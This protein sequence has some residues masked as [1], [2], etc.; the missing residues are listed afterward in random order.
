[1]VSLFNVSCVVVYLPPGN[2]VCEGYVF[3][4]VCHSVHM[5]GGLPQCMLCWDTI[6]PGPGTTLGADHPPGADPPT[7]HPPWTR[8]P[9]GPCTPLDQAPPPRSRPPQ[10]PPWDQAPPTQC[11]LGDTVNKQVVCIP[12]ECNLVTILLT[13]GNKIAFH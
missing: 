10:A 4:R 1:M 8:Q 5:G 2:E 11:M 9:P 13:S 6:P 12:L 7:R 3:T